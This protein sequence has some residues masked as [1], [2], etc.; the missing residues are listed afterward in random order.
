MLRGETM[1][2]IAKQYGVTVNDI[3]QA[4][5]IADPTLIYAGQELVIPG[6]EPPQI[7]LD[8][9]APVESLDISP[10][11]FVE[12]Q[13]G[14]IHLT[15]SS[16]VKVSATFI[17][18]TLDDASEADGTQHTCSYGIP[19]DGAK[20]LSAQHHA[21][22]RNRRADTARREH[23][24]DFG[25][26][27]PR[28]EFIWRQAAPGWSTRS[29]DKERTGEAEPD[30]QQF[31]ADALFRWSARLAGSSP[32]SSPFGSTRSYNGGD[33]SRYHTGTDF[34]SIGGTPIM[35]PAAGQI[36]FV[37]PLD[38]RGNVT[39]IDHGWGVF[40]VY[41]HQTEQY[42]YVGD[43]VT[44]GQVIGTTGST[45]RVTGPHLHWELWVNGI[46]VNPMQWVSTSF[47]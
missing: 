31:H 16:A 6:F 29:M 9:P 4:N 32:L 41:C 43:V 47:S 25:E 44:A 8:M 11:V 12:G 17:D 38:V 46:P 40:T 10:L 22:G 7:A 21:D 13:T 34:A 33:F 3:A 18:Q 19:R 36:V 20:H 1:Y 42:V 24:G 37:D 45:G 28:D 5:N 26:V 27:R 15:T 2:R 35:A 14:R 39:I 23:S 30:H